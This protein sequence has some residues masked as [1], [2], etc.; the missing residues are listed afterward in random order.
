MIV[1]LVSYH[2]DHRTGDIQ[3]T[4]SQILNISAAVIVTTP[5]RLS[6]V[7]VVKG[8]DLFDTV[9]I[10]CVAVVENMAEYSTYNF[11][12]TFYDT[13]RAQIE[14]AYS[15][16]V[17]FSPNEITKKDDVLDVITK[18][19]DSISQLIQRAVEKQRRPIRLFGDGHN[20]RL[21]E[22]WGIETIVSLP[23]QESVSQCADKG[24]PYVLQ[25]PESEVAD[26]M[27]DLATSVVEEIDRLAQEGGADNGAVRYDPVTDRLL[28]G[29]S[30]I[31]SPFDL[32]TACR[33]AVC[34][35]EFTGRT[36]LDK[37]KV[38]KDVKPRSMARIGRYAVSIDW[39]DGHK[40]LY[41]FKSIAKLANSS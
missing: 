9:N 32:R 39:T 15:A 26:L 22:M 40:S 29:E 36:L 10:P 18:S 30:L 20:A 28:C 13:L 3:L 16:A 37:T 7:D 11:D 5:Q 25:F 41:P 38:P 34:V 2:Y 24:L 17:L 33:C 14:G 19:S 23:L 6:F 8:I 21:K 4:L 35:E 27:V 12:A 31:V 1:I